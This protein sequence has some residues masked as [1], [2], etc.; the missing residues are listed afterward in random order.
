MRGYF[1]HDFKPLKI[2]IGGLSD[3]EKPPW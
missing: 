1:A 3:L 2:G